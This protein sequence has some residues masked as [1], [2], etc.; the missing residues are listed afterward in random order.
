MPANFVVVA[1]IEDKDCDVIF[2]KVLVT[3]DDDMPVITKT[4][5][6]ISLNVDETLGGDGTDFDDPFNV[7]CERRLDHRDD[8]ALASLPAALT[9]PAY[10]TVIGADE[11]DG[12]SLS[13]FNAGADGL[14]SA[15]YGLKITGGGSTGLIDTATGFSIELVQNGNVME[16]GARWQQGDQGCGRLPSPSTRA[17]EFSMAQYRA[18]NHG[19]EEGEF[20]APD[21]VASMCRASCPH[22]GGDRQGR[23]HRLCVE[24]HQRRHHLRRRWSDR[25]QGLRHFDSGARR[26]GQQADAGYDDPNFTND[27]VRTATRSKATRIVA[28]P[29]VLTHWDARSV[30]RPA[31]PWPVLGP[32]GLRRSRLDQVFPADRLGRDRLTDTAFQTPITW[33]PSGVVVKGKDGLGNLV[34]A[35]SIDRT[36]AR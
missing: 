25:D 14:Q 10:G 15:V 21:E 29:A 2:S 8:E 33:S 4:E 19:N 35:I 16:G 3:I 17:Q 20:G 26:D 34:F 23:R 13:G 31:A 22:A 27:G 9:I 7:R 11:A 28:L 6:T 30:L 1:E 18:I 5:N 32:A 24:G 12:A 36:P